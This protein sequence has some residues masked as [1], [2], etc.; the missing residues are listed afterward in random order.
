MILRQHDEDRCWE[1][2]LAAS[3]NPS[4]DSITFEEF[5]ERAKTHDA[6]VKTEEQGLC[7]EQMEKQIKKA[8]QI[9]SKFAPIPE[10]GG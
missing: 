2:Y 8:E 5:L 6:E 3:A 1:L 4:L 10:V 7:R 9:L